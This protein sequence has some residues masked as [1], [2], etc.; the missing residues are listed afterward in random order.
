MIPNQ[1][2]DVLSQPVVTAPTFI[3]TL[4]VPLSVPCSNVSALAE[5][6]DFAHDLYFGGSWTCPTGGICENARCVKCGEH[7]RDTVCMEEL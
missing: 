4:G 7:S 5:I 3:F 2:S 6:D 1:K